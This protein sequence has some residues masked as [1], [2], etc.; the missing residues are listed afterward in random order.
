MNT[1]A[2]SCFIIAGA[3]LLAA[4]DQKTSAPATGSSVVA[5]PSGNTTATL[6]ASPNPVPAGST[7][8]STTIKWSTGGSPTAQVYVSTNGGPEA[9]FASD[10]EG[11][12]EA[13]WIQ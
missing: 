12:S 8:G 13:P 6:T 3:L 5:S 4:C 9:L 1:Q 10:G 11:S 7:P 2:W